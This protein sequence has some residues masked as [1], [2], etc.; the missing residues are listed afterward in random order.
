MTF[1]VSSSGCT[2]SIAV[3]RFSSAR[4]ERF[5]VGSLTLS[6]R[7]LS[8]PILVYPGGRDISSVS[9]A[10]SSSRKKKKKQ[11]L[12]QNHVKE[13]YEE[14]DAFE[15]LFKQLEEDLKN[16][17]MSFND[18]DDEITEEDLVMLEREL[19]DALGGDD[20]ELLSSVLSDAETDG[21]AN[22]GEEEDDDDDD[23]ELLSSVLSDTETDGDSNNEEEDDDDDAELLSS[24]LSDT[25]T[26]GDSNKEEDD[27]DD[28]DDCE[29]DGRQVNLRSWQLRKLAKALKAGRRKTSI[30]SLAAELCL[31]RAIVLDLLRDPPPNLLMMSLSLPDEPRAPV[32]EREAKPSETV[33]EDIRTD[34]VEPE[35]KSKVPVHVMQRRWSAQKRLKRVH[36]DTL[37]RIYKR[38]KRP[39]NAMINSIVHVTNLPRRR[40]VKWFED[41][42]AED[43]VPEDRVP[44]RRSVAEAL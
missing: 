38:T 21:D 25:E 37:E 43:G 35:A 7:P 19:E 16:D 36:V 40:V 24:V 18:S 2:K 12:S 4:C 20:A 44:Y 42:R 30:K 28:D 22:N 14:E 6:R 26:D 17:D 10:A 32:L 29:G 33:L 39:T 27:D 15:L 11:N 34:H 8:F 1:A 23:A 5:N 9:V 41:K 3:Q 31:D 13:E